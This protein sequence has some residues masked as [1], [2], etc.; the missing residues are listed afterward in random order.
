MLLAAPR[1]ARMALSKSMPKEKARKKPRTCTE[2]FDPS[3]LAKDLEWIVEMDR[4]PF[5]ISGSE[6]SKTKLYVGPNREVQ[7]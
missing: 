7:I 1:I 4:P 2:E 5:D 3:A 6:Y